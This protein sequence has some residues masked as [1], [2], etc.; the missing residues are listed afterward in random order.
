[1]RR[2]GIVA[3]VLVAVLGVDSASARAQSTDP[4][5]S[6]DLAI[7]PLWMGRTTLA[8]GD[9]RETTS[10]GDP[11]RLFASSTTLAAMTAG[12]VRLGVPLGRRLEVF[13]DGSF[14]KRQL[15]ITARDDFE[16][17]AAITAAERIEQFTVTGGVM[18][19]VSRSRVAPF[20]AA[21][22]GILRELHEERTLVETGRI[23]LAGGGADILFAARTGGRRAFGARVDAR[24]MLRSKGF[25]LDSS[26]VAPAVGISVF[27]RF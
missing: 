9:A 12:E 20:V 19:F 23:Y 22:A 16:N 11:F 8:T 27:A 25:L 2:A 14:G 7:G 13:G 24:A 17:A 21:E 18:W 10:G 1:M 4:A 26:R 15:R 3:A 5:G 6:I